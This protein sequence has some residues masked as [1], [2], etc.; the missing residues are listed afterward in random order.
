MRCAH[1]VLLIF[2]A[3]AQA[4]MKTLIKKTGK[5]VIGKQKKRKKENKLMAKT[6]KGTSTLQVTVL[7]QVLLQIW[8]TT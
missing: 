7:F 8:T 6:A 3:S 2:K 4:L 5:E 1:L